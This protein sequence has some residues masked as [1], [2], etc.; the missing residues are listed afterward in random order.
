LGFRWLRIGAF[1]RLAGVSVKTARYYASSGLLMPGYIDPSSSYRFYRFDQVLALKRI[2][3]LRG[4]GLSIAELRSWLSLPEGAVQRLGLLEALK[5]RVQ[6]Q[7]A[8]DTQR[9]D[10]LQLLIDEEF[11]IYRPCVAVDPAERPLS[12]VAA[13]TIRERG[14]C[15]AHAIYRMFE[16]AELHVAKYSARANRPPFL[17]LHGARYGDP[18]KDVEV[19]IPILKRSIDAAGGRLIQGAKRAVCERF[20]GPYNQGAAVFEGMR[21]WIGSNGERATGPVREVYWRYGA[22]QNGYSVPKAQLARAPADYLTEIQIPIADS[23]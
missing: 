11:K 12:Q 20:G 23:E 7:I 3:H 16:S 21:R 2:R 4:L 13:Y 14:Q 1:A 10:A 19:C 15:T 22:D 5:S 17:I 18:H 6:A 9:L 8:A